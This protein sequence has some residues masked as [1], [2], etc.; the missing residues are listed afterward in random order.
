[1]EI[2]EEKSSQFLSVGVG[3]A[4]QP[5]PVW[6]CPSLGLLPSHLGIF[7]Q[8]KRLKATLFPFYI[9]KMMI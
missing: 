6:R 7:K 1:M 8:G 2:T 9:Y 5:F 3:S 4:S